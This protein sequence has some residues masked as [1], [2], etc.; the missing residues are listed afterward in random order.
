[1]SKGNGV[2][3]GEELKIAQQ[4]DPDIKNLIHK[5]SV[6]GKWRLKP[7]VQ[8][9][10]VSLMRCEA[11]FKCGMLMWVILGEENIGCRTQVVLPKIMVPNVLTQLHE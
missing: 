5:K 11:S 7:T 8:L 3:S 9:N 6:G 10:W 4:G 1:M 2:V